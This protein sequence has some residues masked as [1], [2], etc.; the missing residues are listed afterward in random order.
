MAKT[1]KQKITTEL[2]KFYYEQLQD[3]LLS[4]TEDLSMKYKKKIVFNVRF[5]I[6]KTNSNS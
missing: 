1:K 3:L 4:K 2:N 6:G 5:D